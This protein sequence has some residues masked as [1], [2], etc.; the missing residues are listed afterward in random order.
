M[1]CEIQ[2][3]IFIQFHPRIKSLVSCGK[4]RVFVKDVRTPKKIHSSIP[5]YC[6]EIHKFMS[7][8][9]VK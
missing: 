3:I 5:P 9:E 7:N 1:Q 2:R 6:T 8:V 4:K